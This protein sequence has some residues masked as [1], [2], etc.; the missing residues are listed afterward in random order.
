MELVPVVAAILLCSTVVSKA[1]F[2]NDGNIEALLNQVL[3]EPTSSNSPTT[4]EEKVV[5]Y[6]DETVTH[7]NITVQIG[8]N[9]DLHCKVNRLNDK[10]VSWVRRAGDKM[11]L[12]SFGHHVYSTDQRYE[13]LFKDP[14]DW[15]LRISY[16]NERDAGH[17]ECQVS[18]HPPIAFT[19]YLAIIVP[20][21]EITDERGVEVK[22]KFYFVGST[23]ELKCY[24]TKVPQPSQFIIWRHESTT[25]NY[26][27]SRGGI[28]VKTDILF[29]GAKSILIVANAQISDSG[30][31][32]CS[33]TD[34]AST[35]VT[36]HVLNGETPAAMQH[37][38]S[39][40][41][42]RL[43]SLW[44]IVTFARILFRFS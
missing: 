34:I 9:I 35:S 39:N 30:K 29:D 42:G 40:R 24:I 18:T 15:Q 4:E 33:L 10:T 21:L 5:P 22:D 36:V 41:C 16:L 37:G 43:H 8:A 6:F 44:V 17:Y 20:H 13:L 12:L 32:T 31:Y 25:L 2:E 1:T 19:V 27:T 14:N 3:W 28:S 11:Q 23:I 38:G 26:D 7:V